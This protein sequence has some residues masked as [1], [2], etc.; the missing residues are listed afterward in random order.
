MLRPPT[1]PTFSMDSPLG[2]S[3]QPEDDEDSS[4]EAY[5]YVF[6]PPRRC[7]KVDS[8][9]IERQR[10]GNQALSP[11]P[12]PP[13]RPRASGAPRRSVAATNPPASPPRRPSSTKATKDTQ[14]SSQPTPTPTPT[15]SVHPIDTLSKKL[16]QQAM[17]LTRVYEELEKQQKQASMYKQQIQEQKL[18]M[19]HLR[20]QRSKQPLPS[21][22]NSKGSSASRATALEQQRRAAQM[23]IGTPST[24]ASLAQKREELERKMK[25]AEAEKKKYE[26]AAKRIEKALVELEVFQNDRMKNLLSE[27]GSNPAEGVTSGSSDPQA[28]LNEQRAYIRVLEEAVHL[29]ATDFQ[30]TG[31]E[32]LLVVLAELRHTIYEQEKDMDEKNHGLAVAQ[33]QLLQ[34]QQSHGSTKEVVATLQEQKEV[35]T[36]RLQEQ[37]TA[38]NAQLDEAHRR[39]QQQEEQAGRLRAV[40]NDAQR[41]EQALQ[42]RLAAATKAQNVT[43][44]QLED[45]TRSVRTLQQ[46]LETLMA[47]WGGGEQQIASLREECAKK[48]AHLDEMNALQEELL[49]SVD[50]Y[51]SKADKAHGRIEKLEGELQE[52]IQKE[53]LAQKQAKEVA[54]SLEEQIRT[55]RESLDAAGRR[56]QQLQTQCTGL[57]QEKSRGEELLAEAQENLQEQI[58]VGDKKRE[59][60]ATRE[61]KCHQ[62]EETLAELEAAVGTAL[63]MMTDTAE[64]SYKQQDL[65]GS[66]KERD[67]EPGER[68]LL[69][70]P[71][72]LRELRVCCQTLATLATDEAPSHCKSVFPSFP[73]LI[74]RVAA[75]GDNLQTEVDLAIASWTRERTDLLETCSALDSTAELCQTEMNKRH[76]EL[77]DCQYQLME[78]TSEVEGYA[79]Q[80]D[81]LDEQVRGIE[82]EREAHRA[83]QQHAVD[84]EAALEAKRALLRDLSAEN[85]RLLAIENAYA[86][87]V[88]AN[89]QRSQRLED[90]RSAIRELTEHTDEMERA[91]ESAATLAEQQNEC[92]L[93]VR[94]SFAVSSPGLSMQ[95]VQM[96]SSKQEQQQRLEGMETR[97]AA[98]AS[99]FVGVAKQCVGFLRPIAT[100]N[101]ALLDELNAIDAEIQRGDLLHLLQM[102]PTVLEE[103]AASCSD[104]S[105]RDQGD[106]MGGSCSREPRGGKRHIKTNASKTTQRA[107]R[108]SN[109]ETIPATAWP[110]WNREVS[111][112][113]HQAEASTHEVPAAERSK[114]ETALLEEQLQLIRAAFRSYRQDAESA[115]DL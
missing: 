55:L 71:P 45:A 40:S 46:Q 89:V 98:F 82:A 18:Q 52:R 6:E 51:A 37:E 113:K 36:Q 110:T 7:R 78:R 80:L 115:V 101:R 25:E 13:P 112:R 3:L 27:G 41:K 90:Q 66:E 114:K 10:G 63:R 109:G 83:L 88:E 76:K 96:E 1:T 11:P 2:R 48:Q 62:V 69:I 67:D 39:L 95:L 29:K 106:F 93:Q 54:Q 99:R 84:Q 59:Q 70:H 23:M 8:L 81:A 57:Q 38:L 94:F 87:E 102:L 56:E 17:E 44:V 97:H 21:V 19:E 28:L 20:T 49:G 61:R 103:Y 68:V 74:A 91:L 4:S 43:E 100:G 86:V 111:A 30:V 33:E 9:T 65:A 73:A 15:P 14:Q 85:H 22:S 35:T 77:L 26:L 64:A 105:E 107:T 5:E 60:L 108:A 75:I 58:Q 24:G 32:E 12:P 42:S 31:H 16:R 50:G 47:Q 53:A 104:P 72:V 92:S 79:L 34:E